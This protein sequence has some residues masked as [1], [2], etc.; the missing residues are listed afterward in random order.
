MRQRRGL[1]HVERADVGTKE[2]TTGY[3]HQ[4]ANGERLFGSKSNP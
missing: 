2:R 3:H 4:V 1:V